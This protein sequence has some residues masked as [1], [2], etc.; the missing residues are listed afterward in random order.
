MVLEAAQAGNS[1]LLTSYLSEDPHL[2]STC[3]EVL[4]AHAC[5]SFVLLYMYCP[6][7]L[8]M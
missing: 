6:C 3:T 4:H 8:L 5:C 7:S 1:D 2:G